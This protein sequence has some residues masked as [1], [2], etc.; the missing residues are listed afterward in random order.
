MEFRLIQKYKVTIVENDSYDILTMIKSGLLPNTDFSSVK[1]LIIGG[2]RIPFWMR[3]EMNSYLPNGN[4]L[5]EYGLVELG[6]IAMESIFTG[7]DTVGRLLNGFTIKIVDEKGERCGINV[8]GE[9]CVKGRYKFLGYYKSEELT[10]AAFDS[11]GFFKTGDIGH[12]DGNGYVYITDRKKDVIDYL[13]GWVFPSEVEDILRKS[14]EIEDVCVV[15]VPY[16][17]A[18]EVPAAAV[19]RANGSKVTENEICK[20]VEGIQCLNNISELSLIIF[21]NSVIFH[22]QVIWQTIASFA[23]VCYSLIPYRCLNGEKLFE[24]KSKIWPPNGTKQKMGNEKR[25][26]VHIRKGM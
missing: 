10:D 14:P 16:D 12:I 11:E 23:E 19:V 7:K 2:C 8:D 20:I 4:I 15:G 1:H 13:F 9:L 24:V 18:S 25:Q 3:E 22:I 26:F 5:N 21:L 6:G 17:E